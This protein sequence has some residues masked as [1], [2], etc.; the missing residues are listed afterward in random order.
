MK[1][2]LGSLL[3]SA[4]FLI[5]VP[6]SSYAASCDCSGPVMHEGGAP[7]WKTGHKMDMDRSGKRMWMKLRL[8]NLDEK[9]KEA[10]KDIKSTL[11]KE[12]ISKT[13]DVRIA[14]V[15][16]KDMLAG[17]SVDIHAVEAKVK[18]IGS[19]QTSLRLL[20]IKSMLEVKALLTPE[21]RKKL[22][23]DFGKYRG[24]EKFRRHMR[25]DWDGS[26]EEG[27]IR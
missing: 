26:A 7:M 27:A 14:R 2:I 10:I 5:A 1:K 19:L 12:A 16:L 11:M 23:E 9:Q 18:Q 21:Q 20:R 15:E 13:A 17:D 3:L 4:L 24:P 8:L 22:R 25:R 6:Y